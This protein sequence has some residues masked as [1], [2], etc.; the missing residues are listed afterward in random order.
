MD[1]YNVYGN[2]IYVTIFCQTVQWHRKRALPRRQRRGEQS[3][4]R[5]HRNAKHECYS[6]HI[7]HAVHKHRCKSKHRN[8]VYIPPSTNGHPSTCGHMH[9]VWIWTTFFGWDIIMNYVWI[10]LRRS[11]RPVTTGPNCGGRLVYGPT[12]EN[13]QRQNPLACTTRSGNKFPFAITLHNNMW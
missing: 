8:I 9:G 13:I 5:F 11:I 6:I 7:T 10:W 4:F 2:R 12:S 3:G 1:T